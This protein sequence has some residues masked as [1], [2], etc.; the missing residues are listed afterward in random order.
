LVAFLKPSFHD[1]Y[2]TSA[3]ITRNSHLAISN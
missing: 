2:A 3:D 1:G